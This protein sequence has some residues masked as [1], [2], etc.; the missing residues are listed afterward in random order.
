MKINLYFFELTV[1]ITASIVP[2]SIKRKV[3]AE[4]KKHD[5]GMIP[6]IKLYRSITGAS[7]QDSKKYVETLCKKD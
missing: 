6:A 4:Y 3:L 7:L 2:S 1:S 5:N